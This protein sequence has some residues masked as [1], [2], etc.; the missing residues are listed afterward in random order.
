MHTE[1]GFTMLTA[2]GE[3]TRAVIETVAD[4]PGDSPARRLAPPPTPP[5]GRPPRQQTTASTMMSFLP[6]DPVETMLAGQCVI[7]DHLLRDGAHDTLRGQQQDIK[8][9]A[10]PQILVAGKSFL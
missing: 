9:R 2:M 1:T 7:F 6:R 10:R 8:L 4:R 3:I 5:A